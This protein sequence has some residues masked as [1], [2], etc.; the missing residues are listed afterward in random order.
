MRQGP[1]CRRQ[2][3]RPRVWPGPLER[4]TSMYGDFSHRRHDTVQK[5][6]CCFMP[7]CK[8]RLRNQT[9]SDQRRANFPPHQ[10][11]QWVPL[12]LGS[13]KHYV[14]HERCVCNLSAQLAPPQHVHGF[15]YPITPK[16][17]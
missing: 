13:T 8:R 1:S 17:R 7:D 3:S 11:R 15:P 5:A 12:L 9:R 2:S 10:D 4:D 14:H 6:R 16:I